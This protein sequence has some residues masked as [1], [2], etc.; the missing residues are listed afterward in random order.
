[1]CCCAWAL[2]GAAVAVLDA[3]GTLVGK[4]VTDQ[5]GYYRIDGLPP[6]SYSCRSDGV[7]RN[8]TLTRSFLFQQNLA[9][10]AK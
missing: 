2:P 6:G 9:A 5:W 8:V 7:T 3:K 4:A 1:M 10:P